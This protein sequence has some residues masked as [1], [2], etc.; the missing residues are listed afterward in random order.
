MLAQAGM[1]GAVGGLMGPLALI[2]LIA[3]GYLTCLCL[4][5]LLVASVRAWNRSRNVE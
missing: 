4:F 2:W 3:A 1:D 5:G